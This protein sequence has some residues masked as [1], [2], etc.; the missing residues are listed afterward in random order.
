MASTITTTKS[1]LIEV[2]LSRAV[3][4]RFL[5]FRPKYAADRGIKSFKDNHA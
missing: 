3:H 5:D 2:F 1:S 4:E